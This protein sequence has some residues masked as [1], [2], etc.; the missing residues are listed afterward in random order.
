MSMRWLPMASHEYVYRGA[1][2]DIEFGQL[3]CLLAGFKQEAPRSRSKM[4]L[5]Q[6]CLYGLLRDGG[7]DDG[8][9]DD[10]ND[11]NHGD[12]KGGDGRG[13]DGD[14]SGDDDKKGD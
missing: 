9:D 11:D 10:D 7:D 13:G 5:T 14:G 4:S 6:L 1:Y 8:G 2:E 3:P 12:N